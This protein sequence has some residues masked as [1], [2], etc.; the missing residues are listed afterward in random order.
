MP[1][2]KRSPVVDE[3]AGGAVV[4]RVEGD[5]DF[6]AAFGAEEVNA[7]VGDELGAAGEDGLAGG[8]VEDGRGEAVGVHLRD[9]DR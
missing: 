7:L 2:P 3:D 6:D 4:G 8:E 1:L 5:L 9:R